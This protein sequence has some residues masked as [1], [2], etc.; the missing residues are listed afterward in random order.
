MATDTFIREVMYDILSKIVPN[1][2][3]F[4]VFYITLPINL[5]LK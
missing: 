1:K 2:F 5:I 3:P 4:I